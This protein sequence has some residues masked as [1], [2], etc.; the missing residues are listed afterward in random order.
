MILAIIAAG[1]MFGEMLQATGMGKNLGDLLSGL[2]LGIF[3]PFLITAILKTAQGSST[4]AVITAASLVTPLLASLGLQSPTA[5]TL[6]ILSMGAGSMVVSHA[7]DA[8]FWVISR[9]SNL[10]TAATLKVYSVATLL[11]GLT[12]QL[13]IWV[14]FIVFG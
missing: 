4:V 3:F 11:M 8:Y 12:V 5:I 2:S 6:A 9:F 1:G 10:E 7:N 14:L 13:I